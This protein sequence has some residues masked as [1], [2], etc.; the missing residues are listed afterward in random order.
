MDRISR[1]RETNLFLSFILP[2]LL[3]PVCSLLKLTHYLVIGGFDSRA[4]EV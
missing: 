2:I 4:C 3:I 1:I